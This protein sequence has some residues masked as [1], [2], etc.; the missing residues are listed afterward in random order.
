M[1]LVIGGTLFLGEW[2]FGSMGWGVVHGLLVFASIA[3]VAVLLILRVPNHLY[4]RAALSGIVVAIVAS[5]IL[6]FGLLNKLYTAIGDASA[7]P[8]NVG[9]RPL[10]V[11]VI[12]GGLVGLL[13]GIFLAATMNARAGGRFTALAGSTVAASSSEP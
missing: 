11:G 2:L 4:L 9:I 3:L 13:A 8:V 1:L 5:V 10:V 12:V 6:G 7:L